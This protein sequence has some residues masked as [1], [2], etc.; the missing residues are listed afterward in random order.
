MSQQPNNIILRGAFQ[1]SPDMNL[2]NSRRPLPSMIREGVKNTVFRKYVLP[3]FFTSPK[4]T[5]YILGCAVS[6]F[7][8]SESSGLQIL[9]G[10]TYIM[11]KFSFWAHKN[12]I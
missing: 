9:S 10:G 7:L 12:N 3:P 11:T 1:L 6:P 2:T 5:P 8:A 4:Y